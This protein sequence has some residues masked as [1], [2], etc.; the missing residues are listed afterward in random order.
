MHNYDANNATLTHPLLS[1]ANTLHNM[2]RIAKDQAMLH[3]GTLFHLKFRSVSY[4]LSTGL[5]HAEKAYLKGG[6]S[7]QEKT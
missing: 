7:F 4:S 6:E 5:V 3:S 2:L 1:M